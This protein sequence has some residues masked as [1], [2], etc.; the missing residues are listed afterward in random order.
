[1][2]F[3]FLS[4]LTASWKSFFDEADLLRE[5]FYYLRYC[6]DL[7]AN[8]SY[9]QLPLALRTQLES[10]A[11]VAVQERNSRVNR[12]DLS[13][14]SKAERDLFDACDAA[15]AA[16]IELPGYRPNRRDDGCIIVC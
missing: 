13:A 8:P 15:C 11:A 12:V 5:I 3:K 4:D 9:P 16:L 14:L 10:A 1:M 6:A 7:Q 2:A